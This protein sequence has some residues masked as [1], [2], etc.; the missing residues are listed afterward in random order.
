[1]THALTVRITTF[2]DRFATIKHEQPIDL[3]ALRKT[4]QTTSAHA[5]DKLPLLKLATFGDLRTPKS[6]LRSND[7]MQ[8]ITGIEVDYDAERVTFEDACAIL[9]EAGV[10]ALAYT[11]PSHTE[12]APR[13]RVLCPLAQEYPPDRRDDFMGRLAGLF[14]GI[15]SAESW[16][17]SQPY[18][19]GCL[20]RNPSHR[21]EIIQ[22]TPIDLLDGLDATWMGRPGTAIGTASEQG[23]VRPVS[24]GGSSVPASSARLEG[25][26]NAVLDTLSR[27]SVDGQKHIRL[28]NAARALGGIQAAA[29]FTDSDAVQWLMD[30]LPDTVADWVRAKSTAAWALS[31]GREK[32]IA[33]EDRL[34][35]NKPN[36]AAR[37][38]PEPEP[39]APGPAGPAAA[40]HTIRVEPG[41]IDVLAT[42]GENALIASALPVFQRGGQLVR[43]LAWEVPASDERATL[44]VGLKPI[45]IAA[46]GDLLNQAAY[47]TKHN[48]RSKRDVPIDPPEKVAAT[49]LSRSGL[50]R[51]PNILGIITAPTLRRDG[52]ILSRSGYDPATRLFLAPDSGLRMPPVGSTRREAEKALDLLSEL[53]AGFPFVEKVDRAVGLSGLISPVCRGALGMVPMHALSAPTA[54]TGKSYFIDLAAAIPTGRIC[55]VATAAKNDERETEKRLTGLLLAGFP[56]IS[57]DNLSDEL[58]GDLL[59]QAVERPIIRLRALGS[60]DIIEIESRANLFANGNN[61]AVAGDMTRRTLL[62]HLDAKM[63]R[64]E[65]RQFT[66]DPVAR[67]LE[68]RGQYIAACLTITRAYIIA[69]K[70]DVLPPIAS[71]GAWSDLIRSPLV[72]LGCADPAQSIQDARRS[73]PVLDTLRQVIESWRSAFGS[74]GETARDAAAAVA[75]FDPN[76]PARLPTNE[77]AKALLALRAALASVASERGQIDAAKLGYWLRKSKDRIV[78]GWKFAVVAAPHGLAVWAV[79]KG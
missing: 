35:P 26:R 43:P 4:I 41:M 63:E 17:L 37:P 7:N 13:W 48:A 79:V 78:D 58:S 70:P 64:P 77:K 59:C 56:V 6:S 36:G 44:A 29:G 66:F 25:Y 22:G 72:W 8:T 24:S 18:Y 74:D 3:A 62:A 21:A 30:A 51:V 42:Y 39:D 16:A 75:K 32:P 20:N 60:S 9:A 28:R 49:I 1:M 11:S 2:V 38:P 73:D 50:W 52:S 10:L 71:F 55:P 27:E 31:K 33:L 46:M 19:F 57:I 47:F 23:K 40:K 68:N 14:G 45:G 15:F 76:Q 67:V 34:Q 61:L 65:E 12:D 69:G 53:L 5:K 54:G